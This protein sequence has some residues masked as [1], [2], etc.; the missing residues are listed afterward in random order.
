MLPEFLGLGL[1]LA[2]S[3]FHAAEKAQVLPAWPMRLYS[4]TVAKPEPPRFR[5]IER[6]VSNWRMEAVWNV[7]L[8]PDSALRL[9]FGKESGTLPRCVKLNNYWCIKTAGW[10][11]EIASDAEG[12]VAF[13]SALEGAAV[14]ALLLRHYYVD[15]N[16][17]SAMSIVSRWVPAQCS[18]QAALPL[19]PLAPPVK[20]VSM[21]AKVL[22]LPAKTHVKLAS[23]TMIIPSLSE[24]SVHD[25][26]QAPPRESLHVRQERLNVPRES[27]NV[28]SAGRHVHLTAAP[29]HPARTRGGLRHSIVRSHMPAMMPAPEIAVGM[30]ERDIKL[31]PV[32]Y[33]ALGLGRA[34]ASPIASCTDDGPRIAA[35]ARHA[36]EGVATGINDDLR[37][38]AED[39]SPAPNLARVMRNMASVEIGPLSV[40][41]RLIDAGI[42]ALADRLRDE[43]TRQEAGAAV[44]P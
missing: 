13:A 43:K 42:A 1:S 44:Q 5:P 31:N 20:A 40:Q 11:G 36:I 21:P 35:Y 10:N 41:A 9:T 17:H 23:T 22:A 24:L 14:A 4:F 8:K 29:P 12:H 38:F 7:A 30:G 32:E 3:V 18:F 2:M 27:L 19:R 26:A 25:F 37:L 6:A 16:R 39:G 33:T 34:L 28:R 15:L